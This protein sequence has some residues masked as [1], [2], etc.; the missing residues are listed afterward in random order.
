[1]KTQKKVRLSKILTDRKF[2]S[3]DKRLF[4][5]YMT[6]SGDLVTL[7]SFVEGSLVNTKIAAFRKGI[8]LACA[9]NDERFVRV[10]EQSFL[11]FLAASD[12]DAELSDIFD[13]TYINRKL[14][15]FIAGYE[16]SQPEEE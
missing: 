8:T 7:N 6:H 14:R 16:D 1:M 10:K 3:D 11:D 2:S 13:R 15:D 12:I 4:V 5:R 9:L